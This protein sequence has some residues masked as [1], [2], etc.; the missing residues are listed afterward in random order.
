MSSEEQKPVTEKL[1]D[2]TDHGRFELFRDGLGTFLVNFART[3]PIL[4]ALH[5]AKSCY[6][7]LGGG[8]FD[9]R[10]HGNTRW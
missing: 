8:A 3:A 5:I 4:S 6:P 10:C 2:D 7:K 9:E 1:I